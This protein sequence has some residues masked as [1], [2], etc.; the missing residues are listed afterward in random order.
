LIQMIWTKT[1]REN[2]PLLH[3]HDQKRKR[4]HS[5]VTEP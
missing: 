2:L 5:S 3:D 4:R 1:G